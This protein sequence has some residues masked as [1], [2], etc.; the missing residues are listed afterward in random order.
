MPNPPSKSD[1]VL[2][3]DEGVATWLDKVLQDVHCWKEIRSA[4]VI[5]FQHAIENDPEL[6][7]GFSRLFDSMPACDLRGQPQVRDYLTMLRCF[8]KFVCQAPSWNPDFLV[9]L[10]FTAILQ[11]PMSMPNG[12]PILADR[13][14]N[15]HFRNIFGEWSRY[16]SSAASTSVLSTDD[17]GW[18]GDNAMH[19]MPDFQTLFECDP[20]KDHWGFTSWDHFFTRRL[21]LGARPVEVPQKGTFITSACES[22]VLRYRSNVATRDPFWLKDT[23]PYSLVQ[24]LDDDPF[25]VDFAGGT[26]YQAFLSPYY[27]HRWHSPVT[28]TIVKARVI[29]GTYFAG[30]PADPSLLDSL[31]QEPVR[32]R[33]KYP[34]LVAFQ[35][36]Q[37][38]LTHMATRALIF[39][40]ADDPKVGL[41]CFIGV[42]MVEVSTCE[43]TVQPGQRVMQGEEIGSFHF[44]GSTHVCIFGPQV[45]LVFLKEEGDFVPVRGSVFG[46]S[47]WIWV[48]TPLIVEDS[49]RWPSPTLNDTILVRCVQ[50]GRETSEHQGHSLEWKLEYETSQV[51]VLRGLGCMTKA[52]V[53]REFLFS[54]CADPFHSPSAALNSSGFLARIIMN[55]QKPPPLP[56]PMASS[57]STLTLRQNSPTIGRSRGSSISTLRSPTLSGH[58]EGP[59]RVSRPPASLGLFPDFA[60]FSFEQYNDKPTS[61]FLARSRSKSQSYASISPISVVAPTPAPSESS[62]VSPTAASWWGRNVRDDI[63]PRPWRDLPRHQGTV[64]SEQTENWNQTKKRVAAATTR[65]LGTSL[66]VTHEALR[67]TSEI[68]DVVPVPGLQA[69]AKVLLDIWDSVQ[70]IDLNRLACLRLTERCADI[71]LSVREEIGEAGEDKLVSSFTGVYNFMTKQAHRPFLKRYLKRE[72]IIRDIANCDKAL[73]EALSMFSISI[74]I[75]I[76]KQVQAVELSRQS[77][78][79]AIYESVVRS[80]QFAAPV[81]SA[82]LQGLGISLPASTT[83]L[84]PSSSHKSLSVQPHEDIHPNAVLPTLQNLHNMQNTLDLAH[85]TA[86]LRTLM[87][88]AVSQSSDAEMIRV[89]QVGRDEMPEA[90]KT[91]QRALERVG[92]VNNPPSPYVPPV[93]APVVAASAPS[94][95]AP[96]S[97]ERSISASS[98]GSSAFGGASPV[99][100]MLDR[101]FMESGI[102]ALRRLSLSKGT[103]LDLPSWTITRYEVDRDAK[104]GMGF[105]SDVYRGTWRNRT[106][107]IK[108]L[109]ECTPRKLFLK[110]VKIWKEFRHPNVLELFGASGA[111][112]EGP[113][114]FVCPYEK[115]GSLNEFLRKIAASNPAFD[116]M[117]GFT[118]RERHASYPGFTPLDGDSGFRHGTRSRHMSVSGDLLQLGG[119]E[120]DLLKF[121][122]EIAKGME[123]LHGRGVL[124]GDLKAANILVDDGIHCLVSDF[125]QSEMKSEVF[126]ISG[127]S[128]P[129][130]GTLRWQA[131]ELM[132][133]HGQL[134]PAM[135]VYGFAICCVEILTMGRIPWPLS[136][137]EDV[138][139]FVTKENTRPSIPV[140]RFNTPALQELLHLC[141]HK[142]PAV[143]PVFTKIV[144]DAKQLRK[145]FCGPSSNPQDIPSPRIPDYREDEDYSSRP[146]P[147]MHPIP[148]LVHPPPHNFGSFS[149]FGGSSTASDS[150]D[151]T[152]HTARETSLSSDD[153]SSSLMNA[154]LS[155][156]EDTVATPLTHMTQEVLFTPSDRTSH[157]AASAPQ[158]NPSEEDLNYLLLGNRD[159]AES[160]QPV[161]ERMA[162]LRNERRY[163]LLLE[164]DFHP[165]LV[166]PLWSPSPI[167]LGA[168]GYLSK[169]SGKFVTF[170]NCFEPD[171]SAAGP[172]KSLPSVHGYGQVTTG[173]QRQDKRNAAL[174]GLDA[175]AGLLTFKN[176]HKY[177]GPIS[178]SVSRRY[179]FPLRTGHKAAYL[180]TESTMY[181]YVE[182]LDAP[183]KWFK[184]NVD[185][186]M[187]VYGPIHQIQKED[188][189][190]VIGTLS[191]PDHALFVS[192]KHPDG[193][194]HFNVFSSTK[195]G[196]PWGTFTT[197]TGSELA[198][199]Y[200]HEPS[201]GNPLSASKVS[202]SSGGSV[203]DTVLVARLRFKPDVTEPTSV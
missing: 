12:F 183:K 40:Q 71:L 1:F 128:P 22:K 18:L 124:H 194:A 92:V 88:E 172:L 150:P 42:G 145:S 199:P 111:S 27:Y 154:S 173:S 201:V 106:V 180:C 75:R 149:F 127:T 59:S 140:S 158:L 14:V 157:A 161:D 86:D 20:A 129:Q 195:S 160:P 110:E 109:A 85:D 115:N 200:Y 25:A 35:D 74:Q 90:L 60:K 47:L 186:I 48:K 143:R 144:Q 136:T 53:D 52:E 188:L 66:L 151:T 44:G 29:E 131:P 112:G 82:T 107:A 152:F 58:G 134:T 122:H 3:L 96:Q 141:W 100:D 196:Q 67:L 190:L 50:D 6:Y 177:E 62:P 117:S 175:I 178:Q 87:R 36:Q 162:K 91:L 169:P 182:S 198:G 137:D 33:H 116:T 148:L 46:V 93:E 98:S 19:N 118:G 119:K 114:F 9:F 203:W 64:P 185:S 79:R 38:F 77:D 57:E 174:R 153:S 7:I 159:G 63:L 132:S 26:V 11:L 70:A 69:A 97:I 146:S 155:Y 184:S 81:P 197:D 202:S 65:V 163:R 135:D 39:I 171:K 139:Y 24:M 192:H 31:A 94:T 21:R 78:T 121:M 23:Q 8:D 37:P 193:Q 165:S 43:I 13:R 89:L 123:Y 54:S 34:D 105:F 168:V 30:I 147:D 5:G 32:F 51:F 133:G 28:G 2:A 45:N 126:R 15:D 16:L 167:A 142:D 108:V 10:P 170:F 56:S 76:L 138:R 101:E 4:A 49:K 189:L 84:P 125:G 61:S 68:L 102:D 99:R 166:L 41:M 187:E 130:H 164:H 191:A 55:P 83:G 120:G 103:D 72:Q 17:D 80:Q 104:I 181:R 156:K 113:W 179:S 95:L 176:N 73:G